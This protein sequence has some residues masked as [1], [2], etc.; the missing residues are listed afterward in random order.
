LIA[1]AVAEVSMRVLLFDVFGTLVDWR[2]SLIDIAEAA[3]ARS[4]VAGDWAGAV[5][6]WRRAYQP[7]LDQAR[8]EPAWR[9]L[10]SLQRGTLDTVLAGRGLVLPAADGDTLVRGWR[11]LRPWP[12][13]RDGLARLRRRHIT[14]TLS[15]GH[16]ALLADLLKV[17]DL[18]VDAVLSAQLAASYKPDPAVYL[19]ALRLL[20]CPPEEAGMVA[21]HAG[22]LRAA[23]A[24][25]LRP[26]FI[27]RPL[28][29]GPAA[30][31]EQPPALDRMIGADGLTELADALDC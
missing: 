11:Q 6:D 24:L 30:G 16:V 4:G 18:R 10:D 23:A 8:Q 22:D 31:P 29:W 1:R 2:S 20:E 3:A 15:N 21:A 13:T 25:G 28:E 9:D 12:D 26:V 5:D 7:A 14:A 17:G 19:T 27:N